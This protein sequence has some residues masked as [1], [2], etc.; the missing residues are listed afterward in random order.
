MS[1]I[2]CPECGAQT[3]PGTDYCEH[4]GASLSS[5][6]SDRSAVTA[7]REEALLRRFGGTPSPARVQAPPQPR[8]GGG[9]ETGRQQKPV[10]R[11]IL[12]VA[13]VVFGGCVGI[14][15]VGGVINVLI[16]GM[17][18]TEERGTSDAQAARL[19]YA[20]SMAVSLSEGHGDFDGGS[21]WV[22]PPGTTLLLLYEEFDHEAWVP[23]IEGM[24][25]KET[26]R[27]L[28]FKQVTLADGKGHRW[29]IIL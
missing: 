6:P 23:V 25:D 20:A 11:G 26:L 9:A 4:C 19:A 12:I 5:P 7:D 3:V 27:E 18:D 15:L 1:L 29:D 8:P 17:P 13:A 16:G 14:P 24:L 28:G 21:A 10:R 2:T 22:E